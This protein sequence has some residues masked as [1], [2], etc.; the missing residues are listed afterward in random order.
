MSKKAMLPQTIVEYRAHIARLTVFKLP[1]TVFL[2]AMQ[3]ATVIYALRPSG[4]Y[5]P[6][7][8]N[9]TGAGN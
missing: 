6:M 1:K 9:A 7:L 3:K 8:R 2:F 4:R 5:E